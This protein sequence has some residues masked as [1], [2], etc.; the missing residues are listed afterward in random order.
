VNVLGC[1]QKQKPLS[2]ADDRRQERLIRETPPASLARDRRGAMTRS[3]PGGSPHILLPFC[4]ISP[5]CVPRA[6]NVNTDDAW[7]RDACC[8][9]A[10]ERHKSDQTG[11]ATSQPQAGAAET[12]WRKLLLLP[13]GIRDGARN[14][15]IYIHAVIERMSCAGINI[16]TAQNAFP[17]VAFA[18]QRS[19]RESE[20]ALCR[21]KS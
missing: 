10:Y 13:G 17:A 15:Q 12:T 20:S 3:V 9:A 14:R 18:F 19:P 16:N 7:W 5:G 21:K 4:R 1:P 11:P 8:H 6:A 2:D